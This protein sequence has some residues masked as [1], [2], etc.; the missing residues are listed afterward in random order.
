MDT[1]DK[2]E[3]R[4]VDG[5]PF[6][7]SDTLH[8]GHI[9]VAM[10]KNSIQR[11]FKMNGFE[12][13]DEP[14]F[15]C[16]GLPI[17]MKVNQALGLNT[18]EDVLKYGIAEYN[19]YCKYIIQKY[20]GSWEHIYESIGRE[21]D[22]SK[23]YKTMDTNFM[24]SVWWI[25][26]QLWKKD[27]VY[28]GYRIM[29]YSYASST[30]LSNFEATQEYHEVEDQSIYVKFPIMDNP[31]KKFIAW[32]T[33]PWTLPS[34]FALCLNP[35]ADYVE[36]KPEGTDEIYIISEFSI[37][38]LL[39]KKKKYEVVN[40]KKGIEYEG[41]EYMQ[42][43]TY[44]EQYRS[45]GAYSVQCDSF[46][47]INPSKVV[48]TGIVHMSPAFGEDDMNVCIDKKLL[49]IE[50]IGDICPVDANGNFTEII[51]EY[52][53]MNIFDANPLIIEN[54]KSN[55]LLVKK[56]L[57]K[58]SYPFCW[59]TDKPLIYKAV[60]SFF[61]KVTDIKDRLVE[62][63]KK[64]NWVPEHVGKSRFNNW[65]ENTR[66]WGIS[67]NR[68]FGTPIPVWV[69][70][71]GE[72]MIS[73]GSIAELEELTGVS[74]IKDIHLEF[75]KDLT[76]DSKQGK[77]KLKHCGD[78]LD[79]WFESGAVPLARLHYP[80][81]NADYF[82]KQDYLCDFVCEGIDQ[83]RGWFYTLNVLSV[84]LFDKPAFKNVIVTGLILADDGKK[85]SK[86]LQNYPDPA[87]I[88]DEYSADALRLYLVNS[89][90]VRAEPLK[91]NKLK[92][93]Y[94][95]RKLHQLL[96]SLNFY[97]ESCKT[98]Y[99]KTGKDIDSMMYLKST[100]D[101]DIW[102]MSKL[103]DIV[104]QIDKSMKEFK[105][106]GVLTYIMVFIEDITNWYIKLNRERMKGKYGEEELIISLSVLKFTI[107]KLCIILHP[108]A[109]FTTKTMY[110]ELTMKD[111][112]NEKYVSKD[113]F[114]VNYDSIRKMELLQNIILTYRNIRDESTT[115][116]NSKKGILNAKILVCD[117]QTKDDI[118]NVSDYIKKEINIL[119]L[120][121]IHDKNIMKYHIL[122]DVSVIGKKFRKDRNLIITDLVNTYNKLLKELGI[123]LFKE[124]ISINDEY[125]KFDSS[126]D[127]SK[128][129]GEN[130][131]TK[132]VGQIAFL[133]DFTVTK[134]I[135]DLFMIRTLNL[136]VQQFRKTCGLKVWNK[137]NI[138]IDTDNDNLNGII[139][140]Y[141]DKIE[142]ILGSRLLDD[143]DK[144]DI[145]KIIDTKDTTIE[146]IKLS[147]TLITI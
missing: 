88:I 51:K 39:G 28:R 19:S 138:K 12:F 63:N 147:I 54:I 50:E 11:F 98:Y 115:H 102:I 94:N 6:V 68:F 139:E 144:I 47:E 52:Y 116:T 45:N 46:V 120:E 145:D 74:D 73:I 125:L 113:E 43:F 1:M 143:K 109:P 25:F 53:G 65:L 7:S 69:S 131:K 142:N 101:M 34:H 89:P 130:Y 59:R 20:S 119:N 96:N 133:T 134:E 93:A 140:R 86:R 97:L 126:I 49:T 111:I 99:D 107:S 77:G 55:N 79:C 123:E 118:I 84:A 29:P 2:K 15:D 64:I 128:Y 146:D 16:H 132:I 13:K 14:G 60:S 41:V 10:T 61:V 40:K 121:V 3:L 76:I 100:N 71:D 85:M 106:S 56:E 37:K 83:T 33:T 35:D 122:P 141:K 58:H 82:D 135:E 136:H 32:T 24:E 44:F 36:I 127:V 18:R 117:E 57:Y 42:P 108:F 87:G 31:N 30:P 110:Q 23:Q 81:E 66:D 62:N 78:V 70:D 17:E 95:H 9:L 72:E 91:F 26:N 38:K 27:L 137:I 4:F 92:V 114:N 124:T 105:L 112:T 67:R 8:Y 80:F 129:E 21:P 5:P 90:A 103:G 75:V 104:S 22:Y 48:G